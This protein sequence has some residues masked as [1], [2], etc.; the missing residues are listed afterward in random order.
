[1]DSS[2]AKLSRRRKADDVRVRKAV[3]E[4]EWAAIGIQILAVADLLERNLRRQ[5]PPVVAAP[6]KRA[7]K[8]TAPIDQGDDVQGA[9]LMRFLSVP[10]RVRAHPSSPARRPNPSHFDSACWSGTIQAA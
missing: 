6:M 7:A 5:L 8:V 4:R 2:D 1:M 3:C 9:R 10:V